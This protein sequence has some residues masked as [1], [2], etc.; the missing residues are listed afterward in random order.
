[1]LKYSSD[2]S[3]GTY[4]DDSAHRERQESEHSDIDSYNAYDINCLKLLAL[5]FACFLCCL[6]PLSLCNCGQRSRVA[7]E[8]ARA[9]LSNRVHQ[10]ISS[11]F[12]R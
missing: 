9:L 8:D 4:N 3:S 10:D 5:P 11:A 2:I 1:M 6:W 7:E 12:A